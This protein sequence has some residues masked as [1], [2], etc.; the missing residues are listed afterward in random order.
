MTGGTKGT[1]PAPPGRDRGRRP[2]PADL[3]V[4][5]GLMT[6]AAAAGAIGL[7]T[8]LLDLGPAIS[9]RLPFGSPVLAGAA[10]GLVVA[11]PMA[12]TAVAG[13]RGARETAVLAVAAGAALMGWIVVEVLVIRSFSWLQPFCLGYGAVVLA[14]GLLL[15][16]APGGAPAAD[17]TRDPPVSGRVAG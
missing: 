6:L 1:V 4:V 11:V 14:L 10:L 7:M 5:C 8:G 13:L 17:A 12:L 15:R 2:A 3:A 16:R 9:D